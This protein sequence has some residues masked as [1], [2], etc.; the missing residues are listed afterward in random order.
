MLSRAGRSQIALAVLTGDAHSHDH[1]QQLRYLPALRVLVQAS[2]GSFGG[3]ATYVRKQ[4]CKHDVH[5]L[6][7]G[8]SID[9]GKAP[10]ARSTALTSGPAAVASGL[11]TALGSTPLGILSPLFTS[12][13]L[14]AKPRQFWRWGLST[15]RTA[16]Q[17]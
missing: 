16:L 4:R 15:S 11:H 1:L 7:G 17:A 8:H 6:P 10:A 9:T 14:Q 5:H 13:D 12:L 2:R 3:G